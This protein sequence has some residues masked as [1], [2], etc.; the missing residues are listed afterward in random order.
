MR[1]S[2]TERWILPT[3]DFGRGGWADN[4]ILSIPGIE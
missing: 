4:C 2:I 3:L 1:Y